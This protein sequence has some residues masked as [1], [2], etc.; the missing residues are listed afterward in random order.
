[1]R[2]PAEIRA[3]A[4]RAV[5]A[6]AGEGRTLEAALAGLAA[7]PEGGR[8][9]VQAL[10]F[11]T[12]RWYFELEACL[13]LLSN[14]PVAGL[15]PEIRGL[16][17]VG[18]YQ[19]AHGATPAHAAVSETVE[20][21]RALH[22]PRAAGL[23]N[24]LLRR[25][26]RDGAAILAAAHVG[27]AARHAHPEWL[28]AALARDWPDDWPQL[29]AAGNREPPMWLRVNRRRGSR[30]EYRLRLLAAGQDAAASPFAPDAL[31]LEQPVDVGQL[32]GFADG[33]VSVQDL[34]AQLVPDWLDARP[35][36]RVLDACAAPG[37]KA[38]HLLEREPALAGLVA[39]DV[40]A[41]RARRIHENLARLGLSAE[42]RVADATDTA[43]WWDGRPFDRVLLDVPC[44]GTGVI[45]RH[46]DIKL[47][48]RAGDIPRF[49]ARQRQLLAAGLEVLVPGGR[50]L[51]VT[52]S[53]LAA[54]NDE[55]IRAF[56]AAEPRAEHCSQSARLALP[57]VV[58]VRGP[59][60]GY[61]L[62]GGVADADGF[63]YACLEKRA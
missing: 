5:A 10:A 3:A 37:G 25:F 14:R 42:V 46:P 15:E 52:C 16:A 44:S 47:L 59:G 1:M 60:P 36:M 23:I 4:A 21:A 39:L 20:A 6:V 26:Q 54:E 22:Q 53:L 7:V 34:S 35:G 19:L 11:G 28:L 41:G 62:P 63:Y 2:A 58:P 9:A 8:P 51:Y 17:L 61:T 48:R 57:G 49:A 38:C 30:D 40:D 50:L 43:A 24:A 31:R 27:P 13:R 32:P 55:L 12:V 45:R 29:V 33:D 56:V 18:L